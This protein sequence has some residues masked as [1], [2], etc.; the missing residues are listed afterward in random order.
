MF[1]LP[2]TV[3]DASRSAAYT[4]PLHDTSESHAVPVDKRSHPSTVARPSTHGNFN[5]MSSEQ[6]IM[7]A[8]YLKPNEVIKKVHSKAHDQYRF[9]KRK[10]QD[11]L[12]REQFSEL[13]TQD[14]SDLKTIKKKIDNHASA[15]ASRIKHAAL[16]EEFEA[17]IKTKMQE[18]QHLADTV[19][20]LTHVAHSYYE[21]LVKK[22]EELL[23]E[24]RRNAVLQQQSSEPSLSP[25][26]I[27]HTFVTTTA[28]FHAKSTQ[29]S[30]LCVHS[31]SI[32]ENKT[33][34]GTQGKTFPIS[35]SPPP[36]VPES[37]SDTQAMPPTN[38]DQGFE[39]FNLHYDLP[40]LESGVDD[41]N[42][43]EFEQILDSVDNADITQRVTAENMPSRSYSSSP[44]GKLFIPDQAGQLPENVIVKRTQSVQSARDQSEFLLAA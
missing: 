26:N 36:P 16:I 15:V 7:R 2:T 19:V 12:R 30:S 37:S 33:Q 28:P 1:R 24:K 18:N 14:R 35:P 13:Q 44:P 10:K 5:P 3:D 6:I 38:V 39:D 22:D 29:A 20:K 21:Q 17:I 41:K 42:G 40:D 27:N 9:E 23:I 43:L 32:S 11:E 31:C 4:H 8:R 34:G 25:A